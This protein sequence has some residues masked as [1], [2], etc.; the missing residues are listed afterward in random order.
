MKKIIIISEGINTGT[1]LINQLQTLL[2]RFVTIENILLSEMNS[3]DISAN[4]ILFTTEHVKN[5][6]IRYLDP[7]IKFLVAQRVIN[8]K[9]IKEI[10]NIKKGE[11]V[12]LVNDDYSTAKEAIDQLMELGL[13]HIKYYPYYP[14]CISYPELETIITPGEPQLIPYTPKSLIDI[15]TRI[16]DIKSI[17]DIE[18]I[19]ELEQTI[20][21]SLV[22]NYIRDIVEITRSIDESRKSTEESEKM[23]E[24]ILDSIDYGIGFIDNN[25][26]IIRINS[27]CEYILGKK[28]K[29]ILNKNIRYF[30]EYK[31]NKTFEEIN[32]IVEIDNKRVFIETRKVIFASKIGY[33]VYLKDKG[34]VDK[35]RFENERKY[36]DIINLKLHNFDDYL[37]INKEALDMIDRAKKFSKTESTIL[38]EG[39][40]GTGK[41]ILAQAIHM[42][43]YRRNNIFIPINMTTISSNLLESELFGYEEGTFT[44]ALK[45][46]KSGLFEI[47]DGGTIFIDE[48]GDIPLD[49][50]SKLLRVLEEKR[51]RKVGGIEEVSI[52][53]RVIAATNKNLLELVEKGTFRIDLFFR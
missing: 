38:I 16:L 17:H 12:L 13:D 50:Q 7:T 5:R 19:L 23:L 15:N 35:S 8:H 20:D 24:M 2:G 45:G 3:M 18:H 1:R 9:N 51:I 30:L 26:K 46:G 6:S 47:A 21:Y 4:L 25:G 27:K 53:V 28:K 11:H 36:K 42:N 34:K 52:D 22:T 41:E 32:K 14:G 10:I 29:D 39:E 40:N 33:I 48:I 43:S 37:T 49:V 44:G 31:D